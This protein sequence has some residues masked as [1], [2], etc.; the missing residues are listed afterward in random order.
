MQWMHFA[1]LNK[2]FVSGFVFRLKPWKFSSKHK[3]LKWKPFITESPEP[4]AI[5][6]IHAVE[7][8]TALHLLQTVCQTRKVP[9]TCPMY[10]LYP[11]GLLLCLVDCFFDTLRNWMPNQWVSLLY[12]SEGRRP[13]ARRVGHE[14]EGGICCRLTWFWCENHVVYSAVHLN[15]PVLSS[16]W[17]KCVTLNNLSKESDFGWFNRTDLRFWLQENFVVRKTH[18]YGFKIAKHFSEQFGWM[19]HAWRQFWNVNVEPCRDNFTASIA[20]IEVGGK[21][22]SWKIWHSMQIFVDG[23]SK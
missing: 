21:S 9:T 8:T 17:Q 6:T 1:N 20:K 13:P 18:C 15:F 22:L 19:W 5:R 4:S 14:M 23:Y 10:L 2:R 3:W 16:C 7:P 12:R 11:S